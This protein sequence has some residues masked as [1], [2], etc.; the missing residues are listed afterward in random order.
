[1][2]RPVPVRQNFLAMPAR[3]EPKSPPPVAEGMA[4]KVREEENRRFDLVYVDLSTH[5]DAG[6][7][8]TLL[9]VD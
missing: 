5:S 7:W 1:M 9:R 8:K 4:S 2:S 3:P 6:K